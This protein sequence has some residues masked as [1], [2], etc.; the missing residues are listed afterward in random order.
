MEHTGHRQVEDKG[1]VRLQDGQHEV[2]MFENRLIIVGENS[3]GGYTQISMTP[4]QFK[5]MIVAVLPYYTDKDS[6]PSTPET[7]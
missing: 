2:H 7:V 1:I 4:D 5:E 3:S 6:E